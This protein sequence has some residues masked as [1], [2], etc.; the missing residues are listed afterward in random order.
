[1]KLTEK[2]GL[3]LCF[4]PYRADQFGTAGSAAITDWSNEVSG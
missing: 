3:Q 1:M 4:A 2:G